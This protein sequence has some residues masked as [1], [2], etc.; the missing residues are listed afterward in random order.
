MQHQMEE[1]IKM[2]SKLGAYELIVKT[3]AGVQVLIFTIPT[4]NHCRVLRKPKLAMLIVQ[5]PAPNPA[6]MLV[7][8]SH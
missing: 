7:F 4:R 5:D 1:I 2:T 8:P 6:S 3:R